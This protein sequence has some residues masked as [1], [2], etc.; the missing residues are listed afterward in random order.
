M[1]LFKYKYMHPIKIIRLLFVSLQTASV[2]KPTAHQSDRKSLICV[3]SSL[4]FDPPQRQRL[5]CQEEA[6]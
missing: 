3:R 2:S 5:S 6:P 4:P 1:W